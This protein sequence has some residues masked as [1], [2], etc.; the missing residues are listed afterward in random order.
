MNDS[1]P[2]ASSKDAPKTFAE[3]GAAVP[4]TTTELMFARMR[5]KGDNKELLVPGLAQTR[6]IFVYDWPGIR[7]RFQL[8]LHDRLL[9]FQLRIAPAPTPMALSAVSLKVALGG[10]G[11]GEMLA[12]A[13][14]TTR[15][16]TML[17]VL[18]RYALTQK[19]IEKLSEGGSVISNE[20]LAT[21]DG[22]RR[23]TEQLSKIAHVYGINGQQL[24][25]RIEALSNTLG[26]I[27]VPGMT[28]ET[29]PRRLVRRLELLGKVLEKWSGGESEG[30]ARV[31]SRVALETVR[32]VNNCL[33]HLDAEAGAVDVLLAAWSERIEGVKARADRALWLLDG[34]ERL[35]AA[36]QNVSGKDKGLQAKCLTLMSFVMPMI[37][38]NEVAADEQPA[39][40]AMNSDLVKLIAANEEGVDLETMMEVLG[41]QGAQPPGL[42]NDTSRAKPRRGGLSSQK[43]TQITRLL[44]SVQD[45]PDGAPARKMLADLRSQIVHSRPPRLVRGRRLVCTV[46]EEM[47]IDGETESRTAARIP[48]AAIMPVWTLFVERADKAKLAQLEQ[49]INKPA[50]VAELRK[51]FAATLQPELDDAA[52]FPSKARTL[53]AR[54]GAESH[55]HAMQLMVGASA[56][57]E[58]LMKLRAALPPKPVED[59]KDPDLDRLAEALNDI[60]KAAPEQIQTALFIVM[61]QMAQPFK[62]SNVLEI[63]ANTGRFKSSAGISG[64]VTAAMIGKLE[65]QVQDVRKLVDAV[66]G[67]DS[68]A[69]TT[70]I[71]EAAMALA[72]TIGQCA[73]NFAGTGSTLAVSGS[74]TQTEEVEIMRNKLCDLVGTKL[75]GSGVG[76]LI[77]ALTGA[78]A[79]IGSGPA[80]PS[81]RWPFDQPPDPSFVRNA[82]LYAMALK[83]S[84][85]AAG[86]LGIGEK[87]AGAVLETVEE[88]EKV[89]S[90]LF[91]QMQKANLD[92]SKRPMAGAHVAV[93]SRILEILAGTDRAERLFKRGNELVG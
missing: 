46:F 69:P 48:R 78:P 53:M 93:L 44:E 14:E 88:F 2:S 20:E 83:R 63:L 4:F 32:Y 49:E 84:E 47:L 76:A 13:E 77:S 5:Q 81:V 66:P 51:M 37:P 79:V 45:R 30:E 25:G 70:P 38:T 18:A 52:A 9:H 15:H 62:I 27:G 60:R 73:D 28:A 22:Q 19:I 57:A 85:A 8:S 42:S 82:E 67:A 24:Y 41:P 74:P 43:L 33:S 6:G 31:V 68:N 23:A 29:P 17:P 61:N 71:G 90:V 72:E 16:N 26:C 35:L 92:M 64:F 7:D 21:E 75:A 59:F 87:I 50:G 86:T 34:W 65:G 80:R 3:R 56:I 91:G 39:W 10:S 54:L 11:D 1:A 36:W 58:Q 55:Y 89:A 12:A 40:D